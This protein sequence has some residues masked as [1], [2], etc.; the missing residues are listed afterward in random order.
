MVVKSLEIKNHSYYFWNDMVYL[1]DFNENLIKLVKRESRID[2]DISYIEYLV[3]KTTQYDIDS[4][5]PLY[6]VVRHLVGRIEKIEGSSDR[7]L[8][9][10]QV[11]TK[12]LSIFDKLFSFIKEKIDK[13][14]KDNNK[15]TF[16]NMDDKITEYNTLRFSSD[17]DLPLDTLTEF[18][19]ITIYIGCIIEK[20]NKYY[21]EIHLD[22]CL[23]ESN[24]V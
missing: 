15:V 8:V 18:H 1:D 10:D 13:R 22:E 19:A 2:V 20:G 17:V 14:M 7:Y 12:L 6:L 23:Y 24:I 9:I 21:P 16:G 4:V 5:N 11:N 3:K